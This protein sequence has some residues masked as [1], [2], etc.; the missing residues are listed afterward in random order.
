LLT[1]LE[2]HVRLKTVGPHASEPRLHGSHDAGTG[3]AGAGLEHL[4]ICSSANKAKK[5][6]S[7]SKE[8]AFRMPFSGGSK[9]GKGVGVEL[10]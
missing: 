1:T 3:L 2:V 4:G 9:K 10:V 8:Q 6:K 7:K 5:S